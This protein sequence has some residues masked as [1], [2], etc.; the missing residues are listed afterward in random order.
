V[1]EFLYGHMKVFR[2]CCKR[3][4][5][6]GRSHMSMRE[7]QASGEGDCTAGYVVWQ[8][9]C[10]QR[11]GRRQKARAACGARAAEQCEGVLLFSGSARW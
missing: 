3:K 5:G 2:V 7:V 9:A 1:K 11:G 8:C 10:A 6:Y 4:V